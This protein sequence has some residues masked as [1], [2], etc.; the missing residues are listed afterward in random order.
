MGFRCLQSLKAM[1][2]NGLSDPYVKLHL[3]PGASKVSWKKWLTHKQLDNYR[4][5]SHIRCTKSQHLNDSRLVLQ[6][7]LPN[8][9]KPKGLNREWRCSLSSADRGCSNYI[10]VI[11]DYIPY[12]GA[13]YIR[14]LT[15]LSPARVVGWGHR[16]DLFHSSIRLSIRPSFHP[17][18]T[19]LRF[20][21]L[22]RQ[23]A[24]GIELIF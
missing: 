13:P 20:L 23:I 12:K 11:N 6:L 19:L 17:L 15:V 14:G 24:D 10:G 9:L 2:S 8:T 7:P 1:D 3:L 21:N 22:C 5:I 16:N 18:V 4:K